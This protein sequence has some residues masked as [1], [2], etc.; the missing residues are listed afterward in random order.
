MKPVMESPWVTLGNWKAGLLG[1]EGL[2][3][4][5]GDY[6]SPVETRRAHSGW[7]AVPGELTDVTSRCLLTSSPEAWWPFQDEPHP[8]RAEGAREDQ[9]NR[10]WRRKSWSIAGTCPHGL[11]TRCMLG[12]DTVS[13]SSPQER[14]AATWPE[15]GPQSVSL[16]SSGILISY[17]NGSQF[18]SLK[19]FPNTH[20][21]LIY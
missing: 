7:E 13:A 19:E 1:A 21:H 10:D 17:F 5:R 8:R 6:Q 2:M 11:T 15:E 12:A 3:G 16:G 14:W 9:R 4:E 20:N 18:K